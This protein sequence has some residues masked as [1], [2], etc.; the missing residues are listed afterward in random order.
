M[1]PP[2]HPTRA[3]LIALGG[4]AGA[5]VRWAVVAASPAGTFPWPVLAVNVV[6]SILL[7]ILLTPGRP[8]ADPYGW[9]FDAGAIGFCGGLTTFSTFAVEV[10]HLAQDGRTAAA[11]TY[12][13]V[14]VVAAVAGVM[15]GAT[16]ARRTRGVAP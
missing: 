1:A 7:G 11:I 12:A 6:G 10:V 4:C 3:A 16:V 15:G 5:G 13:A 9:R 2:W 14:S 8:Q